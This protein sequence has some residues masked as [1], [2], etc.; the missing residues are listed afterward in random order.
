MITWRSARAVVTVAATASL[1]TR[2][3]RWVVPSSVVTSSTG[4]LPSS[5]GSMA[6]ETR[7]SGSSYIAKI[8]ETLARSARSK[9]SRPTFGPAIVRSCGRTPPAPYGSRRR[10]AIT[11]RRV[12]ATPSGPT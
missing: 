3:S 12:R 6:P 2:H 9:A 7:R 10:A 5:D 1:Q 8:G 4:C 11:P